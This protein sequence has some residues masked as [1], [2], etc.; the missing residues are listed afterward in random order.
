MSARHKLAARDLVTI[1]LHKRAVQ[2]SVLV[3]GPKVDTQCASDGRRLPRFVDMTV[4]PDDCWATSART[5]TGP[6]NYRR[7]L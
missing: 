7:W 1:E 3:V 6:N 5:G 4:E 2:N